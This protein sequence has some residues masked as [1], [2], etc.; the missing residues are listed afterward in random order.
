[1][2]PE[3]WREIG[4]GERGVEHPESIVVALVF[5]IEFGQAVNA[6]A[7]RVR[8]GQGGLEGGDGLVRLG[9]LLIGE[10][11]PL[12]YCYGFRVGRLA[13]AKYRDGLGRVFSF[14]ENALRPGR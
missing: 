2:N 10:A 8:Q 14:G 7:R 5:R 9:G 1:M 6:N 12:V 11:E 13:K 4:F 3:F